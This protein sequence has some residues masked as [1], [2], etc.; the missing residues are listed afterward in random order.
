M[1]RCLVSFGA[2]LGDPLETI[3]KAA[4]FLQL[5]IGCPPTSFRLSNFYRTP[6]VGG[7][8]GQP[9]FV[10]AVA[11]IETSKNAWELW[12]AVRNTESEFG[13][14]RNQR[15]EA[16]KIDLDI[17][18]FDSLRIW[19]P[20]LKIPHPRMCMRRFILT[21]A[22]EVAADW[23]DPVTDWSIG[24]LA[25]NLQGGQGNL[26]FVTQDEFLGA[27]V[28]E[29]AARKAMA[30]WRKWPLI[31]EAT[32][33]RNRWVSLV[34]AGQFHQPPQA[35]LTV[36]ASSKQSEGAAWE[37]RDRQLARD[38]GLDAGGSTMHRLDGPRYLLPIDDL[39]WAAHELVAALDAMDCPVEL[40]T[41]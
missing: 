22:A 19:T 27:N 2:N 25:A 11:A 32:P 36:F 33:E 37:D 21:P 17:L 15:W 4:E 24:R 10:N 30:Q 38:L 31:P 39:D 12:E 14:S 35:R 13:R 41:S 1:S 6:P 3:Q 9:P 23:N 7:P 28:L 18:L 29:D 34:A 5:Q 26:V 16:R 8:S 40:V 20:Q